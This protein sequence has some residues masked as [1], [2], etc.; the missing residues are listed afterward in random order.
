MSQGVEH[1]PSK[2]EAL[3]SNPGTAKTNKQKIVPPK[4]KK[5]ITSILAQFLRV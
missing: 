2:C 1:L 3:S 4:K 5:S